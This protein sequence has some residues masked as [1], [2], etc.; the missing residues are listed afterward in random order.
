MDTG[1]NL[2]V[3]RPV[4]R[5]VILCACLWAT[6][7]KTFHFKSL[8]MQYIDFFQNPMGSVGAHPHRVEEERL[9]SSLRVF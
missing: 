5:K 3:S 9:L 4:L 1:T 8:P 7:V 6:S 2:W